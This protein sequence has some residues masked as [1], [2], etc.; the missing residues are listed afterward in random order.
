MVKYIPLILTGVLLNAF[1]QVLLKKGMLSIGY[2]EF[3]FQNFFPIVKKVAINLYVLSG[4]A[5][6]VVSVMIWLLVLARVEVS[7]AY[8]F[9]SVGYVVVTLMGYLIFQ[10]SLSWMRV[11]GIAVIIAGVFLLSRS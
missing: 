1:A 9:L 5:S 8:P 6:Y 3:Q 2:F 7:Y 4:L 10:E 11:I